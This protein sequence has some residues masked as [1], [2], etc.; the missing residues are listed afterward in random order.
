MVCEDI[1]TFI[2]WKT[3]IEKLCSDYSACDYEE[4]KSIEAFFRRVEMR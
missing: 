3:A 1:G 4:K 2:D